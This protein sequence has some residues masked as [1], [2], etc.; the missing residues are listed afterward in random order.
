MR[1]WIVLF[2]TQKGTCLMS[3]CLGVPSAGPSPC[4]VLECF[5]V[6]NLCAQLCDT[7][8]AFQFSYGE[9]SAQMLGKLPGTHCPCLGSSPIWDC[10]R[11]ATN[12]KGHGPTLKILFSSKSL[13]WNCCRSVVSKTHALTALTSILVPPDSCQVNI[14]IVP[15]HSHDE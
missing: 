9:K 11:L 4:C 10:P 6:R 3:S 7:N 8:G 2:A 12:H 5:H 15:H 14:H 1:V 13:H